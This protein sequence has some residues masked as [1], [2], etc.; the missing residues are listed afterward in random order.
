MNRLTLFRGSMGGYNLRGRRPGARSDFAG[1]TPDKR[2]GRVQHPLH[3]PNEDYGIRTVGRGC[4]AGVV[5]LHPAL[6]AEDGE[7][8]R[9][10]VDDIRPLLLLPPPPMLPLPLPPAA[11]RASAAAAAAAAATLHD[12]R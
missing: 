4:E 12:R 2:R 11:G 8:L 9:I 3:S 7:N 6:S 10:G 1:R 5:G